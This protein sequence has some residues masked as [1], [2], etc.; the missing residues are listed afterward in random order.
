MEISEV[1][2]FLDIILS[3]FLP[4]HWSPLELVELVELVE[5]MEFVP[6]YSSTK[7]PSEE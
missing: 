2:R 7:T 6:I 5:L 1:F 4:Y 3:S